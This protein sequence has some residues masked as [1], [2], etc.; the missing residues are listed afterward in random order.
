MEAC[1]T[2]RNRNG[3]TLAANDFRRRFGVLPAPPSSFPPLHPLLSALLSLE[4]F[5]SP[6]APAVVGQHDFMFVKLACAEQEGV[7]CG[8]HTACNILAVINAFHSADSGEPAMDVLARCQF[9]STTTVLRLRE[10]Y[11]DNCIRKDDGKPTLAKHRQQLVSEPRVE[12]FFNFLVQFKTA[13][14]NTFP[15]NDRDWEAVTVPQVNNGRV[16][17]TSHF[18]MESTFR[19]VAV[20]VNSLRDKGH[21]RQEIVNM[22]LEYLATRREVLGSLSENTEVCVFDG[23]SLT[24]GLK[25]ALTSFATLLRAG[26]IDQNDPR[27]YFQRNFHYSTIPA[28][29]AWDVVLRGGVLAFPDLRG[30]HFTAMFAFLGPDRKVYIAEADSLTN[31]PRVHA[32]A[33]SYASYFTHPPFT[34]LIVGVVTDLLHDGALSVVLPKP[35]PATKLLDHAKREYTCIANSQEGEDDDT[36][37]RHLSIDID[38]VSASSGGV[39]DSVSV[40]VSSDG[41]TRDMPYVVGELVRDTVA[42]EAQLCGIEA[43]SLFVAGNEAEVLGVT[44]TQEVATLVLEARRRLTVS[45]VR[46]DKKLDKH[47]TV[48]LRLE[49]SLMELLNVLPGIVSGSLGDI[50]NA[51]LL[52]KTYKMRVGSG[53]TFVAARA[54]TYAAA[55]TFAQG[56]DIQVLLEEGVYNMWE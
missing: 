34:K 56:V 44:P 53:D 40:S 28:S 14:I 35:F 16:F 47:F 6:I 8:W 49:D 24:F 51:V 45:F 46:E 22:L 33:S 18:P 27:V 31:K 11:Y 29:V 9:F 13:P 21:S 41:N 26:N 37:L 10:L 38:D 48:Y 30:G 15:E 12:A 52:G 23:V 36:V 20:V 32:S 5:P 17:V 2:P 50:V 3:L 42:R 43:F 19:D 7:T 4:G 1:L 55:G 39:I 54:L 25:E